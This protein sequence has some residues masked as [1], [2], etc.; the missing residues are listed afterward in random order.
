DGEGHAVRRRPGGAS[1]QQE[2]DRRHGGA[3]DVLDHGSWFGSRARPARGAAGRDERVRARAA[4]NRNGGDPVSARDAGAWH[5]IQRARGTRR[6]APDAVDG[7]AAHGA[8][9]ARREGGGS[10]PRPRSAAPYTPR[11]M[12]ELPKTYDPQAI[13]GPITKRWL[14][15]KAFAAAPDSRQQRYVIM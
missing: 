4:P 9:T 12:T 3:K 10:W 2:G 7:R 5:E 11:R 15:S 6:C 13:E 8:T 14:E 1:G